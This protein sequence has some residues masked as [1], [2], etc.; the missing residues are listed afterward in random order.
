MEF[1]VVSK[2]LRLYIKMK[3]R[4]TGGVSFTLVFGKLMNHLALPVLAEAVEGK[5]TRRRG[6]WI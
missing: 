2:E 5:Y 6:T 1:E 4:I 3:Q